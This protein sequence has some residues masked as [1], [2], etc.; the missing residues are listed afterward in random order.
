MNRPRKLAAE[1]R[2]DDQIRWL[3]LISAGPVA[4]AATFFSF[5]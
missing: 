2:I 3:L 4:G 1:K 5:T